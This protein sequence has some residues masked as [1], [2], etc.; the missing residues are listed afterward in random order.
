MLDSKKAAKIECEF[1]RKREGLGF[2][3]ARIYVTLRDNAGAPLGSP[4]ELGWSLELDSDLVELCA[5]A[6][7]LENEAERAGMMFGSRFS[8]LEA[9]YGSAWFDAVLVERVRE[10]FDGEPQVE[11]KLKRIGADQPSTESREYE[12]CV[13]AIDGVIMGRAQALIGPL[14]YSQDDARRIL[15]GGMAYFLDEKFMITSR[16]RLG[17]GR[18]G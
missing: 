17:L 8:Q 11:E 15:D 3:P 14:K 9:E 10:I 13:R 5:R 12:R 4:D 2:G 16:E 1:H 18:R 6:S 7:D